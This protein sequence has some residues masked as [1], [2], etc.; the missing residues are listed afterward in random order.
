[1]GKNEMEEVRSIIKTID[2]KGGATARCESA[3]ITKGMDH[4]IISKRGIDE[5]MKVQLFT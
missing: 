5:K 2:R 3:K 4:K 1:M